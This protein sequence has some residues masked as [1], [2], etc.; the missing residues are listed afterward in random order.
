MTKIYI[1]IGNFIQTSFK[2]TF[3]PI[4]PLRKKT[5]TENAFPKFS[6]K[7]S[8]IKKKTLI[9]LNSTFR[10][11]NHAVSLQFCAWPFRMPLAHAQSSR[12]TIPKDMIT[13]WMD[14]A[15]FKIKLIKKI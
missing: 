3:V 5:P 12:S 1:L 9:P 8:R 11:D 6:A 7:W 14:L 10:F 15:I 13:F 4:R 2:A